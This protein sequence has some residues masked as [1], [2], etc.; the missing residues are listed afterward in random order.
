MEARQLEGDLRELL[1][2]W[3]ND[4]LRAG[5]WYATHFQLEYRLKT[6]TSASARSGHAGDLQE[7]KEFLS[8]A[9]RHVEFRGTTPRAVLRQSPEMKKKYGADHAAVD[10]ANAAPNPAVHDPHPLQMALPPGGEKRC[11]APRVPGAGGGH[12]GRGTWRRR[13]SRAAG[14][15]VG[16]A[17]LGSRPTR[18]AAQP[19]PAGVGWAELAIL[20]T[21]ARG[22]EL[23]RWAGHPRAAQAAR[24]IPAR[25]RCIHC[26]RL[27][28]Q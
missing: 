25:L 13:T 5:R 9:C 3:V 24:P 28:P 8:G 6:T 18:R 19:S 7:C 11:P 14:I 23:G 15:A 2:A 1:P 27:A 12:V 10:I 4:S 22:A 20:A 16:A 21:L 26:G 17:P